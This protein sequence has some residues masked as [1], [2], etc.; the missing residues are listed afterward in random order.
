MLFK[1]LQLALIHLAV[2]MTLVPINS[3]LNRVMIKELALSATLVALLASLPYVFSPIQV[4]IG[5]YSDRHP[6]WGYR[7]SPYIL[8]GLLLCT[9]GVIVS[10]QAAFTLPVEPV[11]GIL[12]GAAAFGAWAM[13]FNLASVSYLSLAAELSGEKGRTRTISAMWF[14]MILGIIA[15][16]AALSRL[17]APY[18]PGRLEQAFVWVGLTALGLGLAGLIGLEPRLARRAKAT[19]ETTDRTG[20]L[21]GAGE[22]NPPSAAA[23]PVTGRVGWGSLLRSIFAYR[24]VRRF[25]IYLVVLLA[26]LLGQDILLEPF[27]GEAFQLSV[28][29][30]TRITSIW[31]GCILAALLAASAL[32]KRWDKHRLARTGAWGAA[33]GFAVIGLSGLAGSVPVFYGGVVL[34]GLA[35]G[36]ATVSNLSLML[37]MTTSRVGMFIGAWGMAEALARLLGGVVSGA[38]RDLVTQGTSAFGTPDPLMGYLSV[39][40]VEAVLLLVSLY[41]LKQIDVGQF[42]RQVEPLHLAGGFAPERSAV[43]P[44]AQEPSA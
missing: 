38:L 13:G 3:T 4:V 39:F 14:V 21:Q 24:E 30:T 20:P 40:A 41:L 23:I 6:V 37:D 9:A 5:A 33:A 1:R 22:N 15:T 17:L 35:T 42:R 18:S 43:E 2:A 29:T 26:A 19:A 31:G 8:L 25:F 28:E 36:L 11:A 7:R 32:E 27:A 10:P 16:A 44:P 12:L 34:L